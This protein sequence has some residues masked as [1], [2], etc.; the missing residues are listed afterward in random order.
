MT[1]DI[2]DRQMVCAW[3]G[4]TAPVVRCAVPPG[5]GWEPILGRPGRTAE[6]CPACVSSRV[7]QDRLP[8]P[9]CDTYVSDREGQR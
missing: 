2:P 6:C 9:G 4:A 8:A 3:C 1:A 5:W 7:W